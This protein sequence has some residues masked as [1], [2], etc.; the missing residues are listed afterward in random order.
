MLQFV[1]SVYSHVTPLRCFLHDELAASPRALD[2]ACSSLHH[3]GH[4]LST[5][6]QCSL[7]F[8]PLQ[9]ELAASQRALDGAL[10]EVRQ[11][12]QLLQQREGEAVDLA[13]AVEDARAQAAKASF[14]S[15]SPGPGVASWSRELMPVCPVA[16]L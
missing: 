3:A 8:V 11:Q 16:C 12:R 6:N 5:S 1:F 9:E 13:R 10:A 2:G 4:I 15:S 14:C 7:C